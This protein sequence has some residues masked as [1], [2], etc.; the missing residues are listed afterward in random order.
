MAVVTWYSILISL[1]WKDFFR[2]QRSKE[3][4]TLLAPSSLTEILPCSPSVPAKSVSTRL[5]E[6]EQVVQAVVPWDL[7]TSPIQALQP[8]R[9]SDTPIS[10]TSPQGKATPQL[11]MMEGAPQWTDLVP[12][13]LGKGFCGVCLHCI[14]FIDSSQVYLSTL[15]LSYYFHVTLMI[16]LLDSNLRTCI[17][18]VWMIVPRWEKKEN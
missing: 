4:Y 16:S 12:D 10:A 13:P 14:V 9:K 8:W 15:F 11:T 1:Y 17:F 5:G 2:N 3:R 18:Y 6:E 7:G